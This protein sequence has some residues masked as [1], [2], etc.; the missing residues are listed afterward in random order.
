V[1][2][3][4]ALGPKLRKDVQIRLQR[5]NWTKLLWIS[6]FMGTKRLITKH[7]YNYLNSFHLVKFLTSQYCVPLSLTYTYSSLNYLL[8]KK[9]PSKTQRNT[10]CLRLDLPTN[11]WVWSKTAWFPISMLRAIL[12]RGSFFTF[13]QT[14]YW[15]DNFQ[16]LNW[17]IWQEMH[18]MQGFFTRIFQWK[19]GIYSSHHYIDTILWLWLAVL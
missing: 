5:Y 1:L 7:L 18:K 3:S 2:Y 15:G 9:N 4:N 6:I 17:Q 12:P 8:A 11:N 10:S 16:K 13:K 14:D 19:A